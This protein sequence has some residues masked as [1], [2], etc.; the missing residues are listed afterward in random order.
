MGARQ[1]AVR[2][3][4]GVVEA[5]T[6]PVVVIQAVGR[7]V[8]DEDP[9]LV[10][11][12]AV[13]ERVGAH[14]H[15]GVAV[16]V[17]VAGHRHGGAEIGIRLSAIHGPARTGDQRIN[18]DRVDRHGVLEG[19]PDSGPAIVIRRFHPGCQFPSGRVVHAQLGVADGAEA[20][21]RHEIDCLAIRGEDRGQV[22]GK[23]EDEVGGLTFH[24]RHHVTSRPGDLLGGRHERETLLQA[25][26]VIDVPLD[27]VSRGR[28]RCGSPRGSGSP[29]RPSMSPLHVRTRRATGSIP[30]RASPR[31]APRLGHRHP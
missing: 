23:T 8:V 28:T 1:L 22:A 20:G 9:T 16:P 6:A 19:Q 18:G 10:R 12:A 15:V 2:A 29:A 4:V 21:R 3:P 17:H 24:A 11:Y 30:K 31:G 13:I 27:P 26:A 5:A 14:D 7:A 25:P